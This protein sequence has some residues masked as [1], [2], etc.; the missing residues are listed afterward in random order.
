MRHGFY[1]SNF[2]PVRNRQRTNWFGCHFITTALLIRE[3]RVQYEET[4]KKKPFLQK[5]LGNKWEKLVTA[6]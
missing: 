4:C 5:G 6:D 2:V 3:V 1:P